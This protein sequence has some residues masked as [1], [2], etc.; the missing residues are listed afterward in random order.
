V[1]RP[2]GN[3]VEP[4]AIYDW[5]LWKFPLGVGKSWRVSATE[6]DSNSMLSNGTGTKVE[7][8]VTVEAI[9]DVKTQTGTFR[10][11]RIRRDIV[12]D[13]LNLQNSLSTGRVIQTL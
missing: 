4:T 13:I 7:F 6:L 10:A 2:D 12:W 5:Q 8:T 11:F 3:T 1:E 9:E